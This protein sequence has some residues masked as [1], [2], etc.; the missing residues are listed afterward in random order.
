MGLLSKFLERRRFSRA[1]AH[2][3]KISS[4]IAPFINAT[5]E[6]AY[7]TLQRNIQSWSL[8]NPTLIS[9]MGY[10]AGIIDAAD[11][12]LGHS[13][14]EDWTATEIV[15]HQIID[16]QL[17][18]IEGIQVFIEANRL[19]IECGGSTI[20][21]MQRDP[22]FMAAMQLGGVDFLSIGQTGFFPKGLFE[23]GLITG[24]KSSE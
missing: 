22:Q 17:D 2:A 6:L 11:N 16:A 5:G 12:T 1:Q 23:L 19:G 15:F 8:S 10:V 3:E 4:L 13:S 18:W 24:G 14:T 9:Y 21:G 20:G 7:N